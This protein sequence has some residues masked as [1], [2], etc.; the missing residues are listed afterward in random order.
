MLVLV[1]NPPYLQ[2]DQHLAKGTSAESHD[3]NIVTLDKNEIEKK[4]EFVDT[5][6][7]KTR[8]RLRLLKQ[9]VTMFGETDAERLDRL[10]KY[11]IALHERMTNA[12]KG[13]D[14]NIL[15]KVEK[16]RPLS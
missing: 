13:H 2:T 1:S 5:D 11:E 12:T 16:V 6:M 4:K 3:S 9:P 10:K 7:V 8:Q 15:Q 14:E